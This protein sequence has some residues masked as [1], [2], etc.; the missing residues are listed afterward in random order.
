M[1]EWSIQHAWKLIPFA[2]ADVH[3]IPTN[4]LPNNDFSRQRCASPCPRKS[5]PRLSG[6]TPV[7]ILLSL[8]QRR[9]AEPL[10]E[11]DVA[12]SRLAPGNQRPFTEFGPEVPRVRIGDNLAGV[13]VRGEALT[14]Q[15]V[16]T[17]LLRTGDFD[18]AVDG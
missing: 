8:L 13:V 14:D 4:A 6:A 5:R 1:S 3:Q 7:A 15:F 18:D 16:E 12:E 10:G 2:R 9:L 11:P 17:E